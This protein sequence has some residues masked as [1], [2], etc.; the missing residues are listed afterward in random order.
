MALAKARKASKQA[1]QWECIAQCVP[2]GSPLARV[3]V[4]YV[5]LPP[6]GR[7]RDL[8]NVIG[9]TKAISDGIAAHIGVDDSKWTLAYE[10]GEP[11]KG[12]KVIVNLRWQET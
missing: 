4:G 9:T 3:S 1:T 7:R 2:R 6:D 10:F 5:F 12:G 8:D 11:V